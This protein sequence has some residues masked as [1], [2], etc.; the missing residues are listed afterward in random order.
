M[1]LFGWAMKGVTMDRR[2]RSEVGMG[3]QP[4]LVEEPVQIVEQP[5]PQEQASAVLFN[6][7]APMPQQNNNFSNPVNTNQS[8]YNQG[9]NPQS[10]SSNQFGNAFAGNTIGN[11]HIMVVTPRN[12]GE[13]LAIVEHLKNNTE[14]VIV[15]F[16]GVSVADTQRRID[17]L[18]GVACG[19]GGT[20]RPLDAFKYIITPS[21]I[22]VR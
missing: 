18:S 9:Y 17:F 21:G 15:N 7:N 13:V 2:N 12:D 1:G 10:Y 5:S 20:L 22:G 3:E 11:R 19:L 6:M 14:A 4:T 8:T 16:E